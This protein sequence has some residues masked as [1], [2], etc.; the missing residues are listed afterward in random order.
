MGDTEA[1]STDSEP[2]QMGVEHLR[3]R[4][5]GDALKI[6]KKLEEVRGTRYQMQSS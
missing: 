6:V 2:T 3:A 1:M 5:Q 4:R